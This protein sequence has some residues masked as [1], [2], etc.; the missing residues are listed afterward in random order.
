MNVDQILINN[1]NFSFNQ[2]QK[3]LNNINLTIKK[4]D[5]LAILGASGSGK[6][7]LLR[8][9][10]NILPASKEDSLTGEITIFGK[11]TKEYLNTGKLSFMFQEPSLM[12]NLSVR[13]NIGFPLKLRGEK[14]NNNLIDELLQVVGLTD[15]Q[16]KYPSELS[17]GMKTR[18]SLARAFMTEPEVLLLDEPFSALDISWRY[19]LY[20]YLEKV[21]TRFNTTVI[22]VTHDIQEAILLGD[23]ITIFSKKGEILES[24]APKKEKLVDFGFESVNSVLA[25]NND[26]IL[27]I[28]R[29]IIVDGLRQLSKTEVDALLEKLSNNNPTKTDLYNLQSLKPYINDDVIYN[30]ASQ[31]WNI[32]NNW[33]LKQ[34]LMWRLLDSKHATYE[35]H[36][37]VAQFIK[38][39]LEAF[40]K[41]SMNAQYFKSGNA[42]RNTIRRFKNLDYHNN[43]NW[44]Y[45]VYLKAITVGHTNNEE[46]NQLIKEYFEKDNIT[47]YE[48]LAKPILS[49]L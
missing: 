44:L 24:I 38:D 21:A 8:V 49:R 19:E 26:E 43:K 13:Q 23:N 34:H 28:Q 40:S 15:H 42:V 1:L 2:D 47:E 25:D 9:I 14:I 37:Q 5:F 16:T 45:L 6:S 20:S 33:N 30:K 10:S 31:L 32:S 12:P 27:D 36:Q 46:A 41:E 18:V 4:S 17:G 48:N 39:D 29:E 22:L 7:T 3:I 11:K 35:L